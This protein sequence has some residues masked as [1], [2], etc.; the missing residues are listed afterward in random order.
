[1]LGFVQMNRDTDRYL[2]LNYQFLTDWH[3]DAELA[4]GSTCPAPWSIIGIAD[5]AMN[6]LKKVFLFV[7]AL[8]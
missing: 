6:F 3:G 5:D 2:I 1:M 7:V 4:Q 8:V